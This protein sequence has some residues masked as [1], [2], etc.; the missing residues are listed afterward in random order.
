MRGLFS[1][2]LAVLVAWPAAAGVVVAKKNPDACAACP[3]AAIG[4]D[5]LCEDANGAALCTWTGTQTQFNFATARSGT[6]WTC[7]DGGNAVLQISN[8]AA[9]NP[10][11]TIS[12]TDVYVTVWVNVI[13]DD[14][15]TYNQNLIGLATSPI[16]VALRYDSPG[17]VFE[18]FWKDQTNTT[19]VV[20]LASSVTNNTWHRVDIHWVSNQ[21]DAGITA[22]WDGSNVDLTGVTDSTLT[23]T[24]TTVYL[25][26]GS[27]VTWQIDN[28]KID[29]DTEPG[30]C[31]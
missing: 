27:G 19:Q 9:E 24:L 13:S 7:N 21:A 29:D 17:N 28:F 26:S 10:T 23:G 18:L 15:S 11:A 14:G 20:T 25:V 5:V 6:G 4:A 1:L 22:K 2:L 12:E 8:G 30:A 16:I 31:Q 3:D